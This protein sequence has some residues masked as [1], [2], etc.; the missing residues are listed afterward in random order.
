MDAAIQRARSE[1]DDFIRE[2][3]AGNGVDFSVKVPVT[4]GQY[5]EHF[6]LSDLKYENG[7][8]SGLIANDPGYVTNV[9][10]GQ[11]WTVRKMEITDWMFTRNNKI[12]GN[13][14]MRPLLKTLPE[15]QAEEMRSRLA[16]P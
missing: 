8:F 6:W 13:Y 11:P 1:V 14:T 9:E 12:H 7:Q 16:D 3:E 4:D 2:F 5:T 15:E 10:F